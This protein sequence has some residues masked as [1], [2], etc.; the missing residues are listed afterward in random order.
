MEIVR[1]KLTRSIKSRWRCDV[2]EGCKIVTFVLGTRGSSY[3]FSICI[4]ISVSG[5][6]SVNCPVTSRN[7]T[8][9]RNA[10]VVASLGNSVPFFFH[11]ETENLIHISDRK[12]WSLV[13][14]N[15]L[16]YKLIPT[17]LIATCSLLTFFS[18]EDSKILKLILKLTFV[19]QIYLTSLKRFLLNSIF[20]ILLPYVVH[21]LPYQ[22][23]EVVLH[24]SFDVILKTWWNSTRILYLNNVKLPC[25]K[26]KRLSGLSRAYYIQG[27]SGSHSL[28]I[29]ADAV[30]Q[31]NQIF[32]V[33]FVRNTA[34]FCDHCFSCKQNLRIHKKKK[35]RIKI[36]ANKIIRLQ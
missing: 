33:L 17:Y 11:L 30:R 18:I 19:S 4:Q 27:P 35:W 2:L 36:G 10:C 7:E 1:V 23:L 22:L 20:Q 3:F 6:A 12:I 26:C 29:L 28:I 5:L 31:D 16:F 25:W 8:K 24:L 32:F 34:S 9:F 14:R 13:E 15:L 21:R